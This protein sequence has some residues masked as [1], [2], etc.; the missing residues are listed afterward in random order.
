MVDKDYFN[1]IPYVKN[2]PS[3]RPNSVIDVHGENYK[4][5]RSLPKYG[6]TNS[7]QELSES[8][9]ATPLGSST[10]L[11]LPI[12][13]S[14]MNSKKIDVDCL[15][16]TNILSPHKLISPSASDKRSRK[17]SVSGISNA[18]FYQSPTRKIGNNKGQEGSSVITS[19][20]IL[21]S[22]LSL[23]GP[24]S[25]TT[26]SLHDL[27]K[28][29][30]L[31]NFSSDS[32]I[33]SA[34]TSAT[35][36][37]QQTTKPIQKQYLLNEQ[38][39][40]NKMRNNRLDDYYTKGITPSINEDDDEIGSEI[41]ED[42]DIDEIEFGTNFFTTTEKGDALSFNDDDLVSISMKYLIEKMDWL[43]QSD[44]NN[45]DIK[46]P[47][48]FLR[49]NSIGSISDV[50]NSQNVKLSESESMLT[51]LSQNPLVQERLEWQTMLFNV[52]KGDI[53]RSEKT[54]LAKQQKLEEISSHYTDQLWIELKAWLSGRSVDDQ[55]KSLTYL[56][57]TSD[58]LFNEIMHFKLEENI[59]IDK[60]NNIVNDILIRYYKSLSYWKN[61]QHMQ[62][63][64]HVTRSPLFNAKIAAMNTFITLNNAF[65]LE[66]NALKQWT[67]NEDLDV[68]FKA[69]SFDIEGV[70]KNDRSFA[71]QI[72]KEKDIETIFQRKIFFRHA[73]W[74]LK[75]KVSFMN[76]LKIYKGMGL[77]FLKKQLTILLLFPMKLV[78]E[79][80]LLRLDYARKLQNPTMM[81]IDQMIDDFSSY[82]KLSVQIKHTV[83][84]Y[85]ADWLFD[86]SLDNKFDETVNE[87]I[88]YLFKLLHLKLVDSSSK[89]FR[90]CKEPEELITNWEQ[91]KNVGYYIEGAGEIIAQGF[92]NLTLR[93]LN[94]LHYYV[95]RQQNH[96]P[97]YQSEQEY[98]KWILSF[99]ENIGSFKRKMNRFSNTLT[100]TFQ[101]SVNYR[102]DN[103]QELLKKLNQSG[104]FLI[105]TG[106]VL[107]DNGVYLFGSDELLGCS[108]KSIMNMLKNTE[109]CSDLVPKLVINNSL[110][111]YNAVEQFIDQDCIF[112][113]EY[114]QDGVSF[115]RLETENTSR[116]NHV[117]S[118]KHKNKSDNNFGTYK[119]YHDDDDE[120]EISG[121]QSKLKSFGYI[122][123]FCPADPILWKGEV[124][125]LTDGNILTVNDLSIKIKPN[126]LVQLN[127]GCASAIEY[128]CDK[129]QYLVG[130]TV[131]FNERRCSINSIENS[132]QKINKAYYRIIHA[133]LFNHKKIVASVQKKFKEVQSLNNVF[134]FCR[135]FARSFLRLNVATYEKKSIIIMLMLKLSINWLSFLVDDCD[136][137]DP[138]TFR[139]CVPAMEFAMQMTNGW[140]ILCIDQSQFNTLKEKI[141]GC[142]SLLIAHFDIMGVRSSSREAECAITTQTRPNIYVEEDD[143]DLIMEINSE[144]RLQSIKDLEMNMLRG[145]RQVGKVLDDTDKKN[146]YLLSLASSLSNVSIRW[147]KCDFIGGGSFGSVFSAVNLDTGDILAVK[148]VKIHAAGSMKQVFPSIKEEMNILEMLNH[149]NIVQYYGVEVHR[150]KVNIFMEYCEGG[151]LA[152]LLEHGRIED[153]MVTQIYTLQLVEGLSYLHQS[154][155]VHRDIKPE[156]ILLDFNGVIKYVDFG[157]AKIIAK[158]GSKVAT[159]SKNNINAMIGTPMYMAPEAITGTCHGKFGSDDIWSLASVVLEMVTGRRPWANLDNEWAIMYQVAA[160]HVPQFPTK[161]EMSNSGRK[162]LSRCLIQDANKRATAVELLVDPWIVEIRNIAFGDS[163]ITP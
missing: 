66:I 149:P 76:N 128:H 75:A 30:S 147:K 132:L 47:L 161:K 160:G 139:W 109:I 130:D 133:V 97:D 148:Q 107:E 112:I 124:Y 89:T 93:L 100:K 29:Q 162:F 70:Y 131:S 18:Q 90:N 38:L 72:L 111:I 134:M 106:G 15:K 43:K 140:N 94:K 40:L 82:I 113:E 141:S 27:T 61:I 84:I 13:V 86:I 54:K 48:D 12:V 127:K 55:K 103:T 155:V 87:A 92:S 5:N 56:R 85:C 108:D 99:M 65:S 91:L 150:D 151:S 83:E 63:E 101:N 104:H 46:R 42:I 69:T 62:K 67:G 60:A 81:M 154:G 2:V 137:T 117:S 11:K 144:L 57:N 118:N 9:T 4:T 105:Y 114:R 136:P 8:P 158:N 51:K 49:R 36:T 142:M 159:E 163:T 32:S 37:L 126:T 31:E 146:Q 80:I 22:N 16:S 45:P 33:R 77:P 157:A 19:A 102:V 153:E 20:L 110:V 25:T 143:D 135:D 119:V 34:T 125:N 73:P 96:P 120:T 123:A 88:K 145:R 7:H 122:L 24:Y 71:E 1:F 23:I 21:P 6:F 129:F 28:Q 10:S 98:E 79:I 52:L 152:S 14:P 116:G 58:S 59:D 35:S 68:K 156:N 41:T 50:E 3:S 95:L 115:Y 64:K 44:P 53:V 74:I 78:K 26:N 39:Y 121:L 138:K 17:S